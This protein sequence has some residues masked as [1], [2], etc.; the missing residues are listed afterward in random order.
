M[1]CLK[2]E[3]LSSFKNVILWIYRKK[4]RSSWVTPKNQSERFLLISN[5]FYLYRSFSYW[6][7]VQFCA[8]YFFWCCSFKIVPLIKNISGCYVLEVNVGFDGICFGFHLFPLEMY[9]ENSVYIGISPFF[10]KSFHLHSN[11]SCRSY[12]FIFL[13]SFSSYKV[14]LPLNSGIYECYYKNE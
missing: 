10:I 9:C 2:L 6:N 13:F 8:R 1:G 7:F 3:N 12:N 11:K 4:I 14:N 5:N